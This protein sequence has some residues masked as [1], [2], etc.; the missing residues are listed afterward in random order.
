[1]EKA[2]F[3]PC[4]SPE[5]TWCPTPNLSPLW[6]LLSGCRP[7]THGP[8]LFLPLHLCSHWVSCPGGSSCPCAPS[9]AGMRFPA[10]QPRSGKAHI[11]HSSVCPLP[12]PAKC[13]AHTGNH[14]R[15]LA[16]GWAPRSPQGSDSMMPHSHG[17][18]IH[19]HLTGNPIS[20]Q[21]PVKEPGWSH[22]QRQGPGHSCVTWP[23]GTQGSFLRALQAPSP[24]TLPCP[25]QTSHGPLPPGPSRSPHPT[26]LLSCLPS[27]LPQ[28]TPSQVSVQCPGA[29]QTLPETPSVGCPSL[30][31]CPLP[32]WALSPVSG[33]TTQRPASG[34]ILPAPSL[35]P[36]AGEW[37]RDFQ[38]LGLCEKSSRSDPSVPPATCGCLDV[39]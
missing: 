16:G 38:G 21:R 32:T 24:P 13:L 22:R 11:S 9:C 36:R 7:L 31:S 10:H 20:G 5:H 19:Q 6:P 18:A 25:A 2:L 26:L 39:N 34:L 3:Q 1:M 27:D 33:L 8:S 29:W 17:A 15:V 35:Q 37:V 14:A 28:A 23:T 30:F 12:T 4:S